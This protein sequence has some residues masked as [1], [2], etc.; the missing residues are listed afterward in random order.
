MTTRLRKHA[1]LLNLLNKADPKLKKVLLKH[2]CT[3]DFIR[4]VADCCLNIIKGNVPLTPKQLKLLSSKK[5]VVRTLAAKKISLKKKKRIVQSGGFLG[6]ILPA[7]ISGL[8][9]L[10]G[11][12]FNG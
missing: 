4:C 3:N 7:I 12:L 11:G 10:F 1:G 9:G 5:Q 8:G 2:H 6:A